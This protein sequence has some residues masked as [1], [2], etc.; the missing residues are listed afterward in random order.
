VVPPT[1]MHPFV[2]RPL[3]PAL[4]LWSG[5]IGG[6]ETFTAD[7]ARAMQA[8]GAEP[9][10]VF[11]LKGA[12][13][14]DRLNHFGIPN[15]ALGLRRGRA[16]LHAPRR[17]ARAVSASGSDIA[18]LVESGYLA[19]ALRVGG[20]KAPIIGIEHGSLLQMQRL[21][22]LM[23]LIRAA[24]RVSGSKACSAVVAVSEYMTERVS[25]RR[26]RR[27][28]VCIPNGVDLDRFSPATNGGT[29]GGEDSAIVIGCAAR[30]VDGKGVE[31]V[32]QALAH[33]SLDRA[34][35]RIAG[36]GPRLGA[37]KALARSL[38]VDARAEFLGPVLDMPAFWRSTDVAVVPSNGA[39]ESFGMAAVEAMACAKPVVVSDSGALPDLVVDGETGRV[40]RAG[41]VTALTRAIGS[42]VQN[43]TERICHGLN[44]RQRCERHFALDQSAS[45]YLELCAQLVRERAREK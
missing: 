10:V 45:R 29:P 42:Y 30:L 37:L 43:S 34:R 17:L 16:V 38:A 11:V 3:R 32:I 25:I 20:Y 33:P 13:L 12:P 24:D 5:F 19:A 14:N 15:S 8:R 21:H 1:F 44:A 7:L 35:L 28:V 6:A 39:V 41:D 23:R 31:D 26:P 27:R 4:V 18:I 2:E 22:P 9:A 40:V 36:D